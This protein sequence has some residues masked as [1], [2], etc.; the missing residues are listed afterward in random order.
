MRHGGMVLCDGVKMLYN[1]LCQ[2]WDR[3]KGGIIYIHLDRLSRRW[4]CQASVIVFHLHCKINPVSLSSILKPEGALLA[5]LHSASRS[6]PNTSCSAVRCSA[7]Q[8]SQQGRRHGLFKE[9]V[10][11]RP[12]HPT[13]DLSLVRKANRV[14]LHVSVSVPSPT[15]VAGLSVGDRWKWWRMVA[16]VGGVYSLMPRS[17]RRLP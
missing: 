2:T 5:G 9:T 13:R 15:D 4:E 3:F 6:I 7:V 16:D 10:D 12:S 11:R 17:G 1:R 8:C 14:C